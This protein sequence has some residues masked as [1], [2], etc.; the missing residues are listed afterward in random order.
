MAKFSL[1]SRTGIPSALSISYDLSTLM[2]GFDNGEM[3]SFRIT[4]ELLERFRQKSVEY[5]TKEA[6]SGDKWATFGA[7]AT[8]PPK[9][10]YPKGGE[11][12][13]GYVDD[14]YIFGQDGDTS[15]KLYNKFSKSN[16]F[17]KKLK[18]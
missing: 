16:R 13:D 14:I 18:Y 5:R 8:I 1:P 3:V 15:S 2:V 10:I 9:T 11:W 7:L 6:R 17:I 4:P 12:H